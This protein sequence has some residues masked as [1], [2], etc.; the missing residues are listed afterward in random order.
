MLQGIIAVISFIGA[1]IGSLL[2]DR[3]G[4]RKMLFTAS[5][6]FV[7]WFVI[8]AGLSAKYAGSTNV[9]ASNATVAIIYLFG[10][11]FSIGF[12]PFQALYPVEC[13]TFETRAKGMAVYNLYVYLSSNPLPSSPSNP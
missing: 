9:A 6:L 1:L 4:R 8:L 5:C 12:T 11:T 7:M 3:V 2:V 10:F 13:L